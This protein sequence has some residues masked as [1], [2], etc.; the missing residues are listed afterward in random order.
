MNKNQQAR[1]GVHKLNG[2]LIIILAALVFGCNKP[3]VPMNDL[4][5]FEQVNLVANSSEYHPVTVDPTLLNAF[6]IAWSPNGIAWVNSVGGHV[7][8][9][10][11][12]EGG[13]VR[14]PVNIPSPSNTAGGLPTGIVF[15]GGLGFNLSNGPSLFLF[16]GF[17]GVLSG[18]NPASGDNAKRLRTLPGAAYTGL[19]IASDHG[20]NLIYGANFGANRIDVWDT[21]FS[22]VTMSFKDPEIPAEYS[23]YNIQAVGEKLFVMYAQLSLTGGVVGHVA[24][25][26]KGFVSV[27]NTDGSFVKRFAS[28]GSLNI[29]WGVTL[30][31]ASFLEKHDMNTKTSIENNNDEATNYSGNHDSKEPVILVGNFGD[32]RIN[33]YSLDAKYLGQLRSHDHTI[34]IDGLWALSFAPSTATAIDPARLYF[35]AGPDN[36]ADGL[37]G[38]LIKR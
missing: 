1:I 29:P 24:G 10:Y 19:A 21:A 17:D 27:F 7:S 15:S 25:S 2:L 20:R 14:A 26:G 32:G 35:S 16:T 28:R 31:P 4:R 23:P 36:E 30:A 8:E 34:V 22:R 13:I 18:W 12:G 33:V 11:N 6:G 5:N 3:H 37:F 9:L 38:Y